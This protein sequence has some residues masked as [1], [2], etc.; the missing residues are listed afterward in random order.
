[1]KKLFLISLLFLLVQ[2]TFAQTKTITGTVKNKADGIPIPGVTVLIKGTTTSS[3]TNLDGKYAIVA[4]PSDILVFSYIGYETR[5]LKATSSSLN[6]TL[7][8]GA[9]SLKEVTVTGAFGINRPKEALG[10]ATQG[11][12]GDEISDTQRENFVNALQGRIAGLT[13]TSTSGSPGASPPL[14]LEGV[15]R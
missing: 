7:T 9:E 2:T 10:Y 6:L 5:E 13:V 12:K 15:T 4:E 11:V 1:M 3:V 14:H 8:Q